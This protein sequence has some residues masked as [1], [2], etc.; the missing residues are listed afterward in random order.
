[1]ILLSLLACAPSSEPQFWLLRYQP[2]VLDRSHDVYDAT[3][4]GYEAWDSADV[5]PE[6]S[7]WMSEE[8][9]AM[10]DGVTYVSFQVDDDGSALA[11]H[12]GNA[13]F[14]TYA[15]GVLKV[16]W[17]WFTTESSRDE[18]ESGYVYENIWTDGMRETLSLTMDGD[19]G[20]GVI[21]YVDYEERETSQS[22]LWEDDLTLSTL[23]AE[24][25]DGVRYTN[26]NVA[27]DCTDTLCTTFAEHEDVWLSEF[28]AERV[29]SDEPA[30]LTFVGNGAGVE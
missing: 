18:H 27:P 15:D 20:A 26:Y 22:D 30:Y 3:F 16:E 9:S 24:D 28:T 5:E 23:T 14:G 6:P 21:R 12:F 7:E 2:A 13:L 11:T 19:I 4:I 10:S 1:M 25:A 17:D 8:S 29:Y